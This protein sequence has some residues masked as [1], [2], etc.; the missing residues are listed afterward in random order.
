M[1]FALLCDVKESDTTI[2]HVGPDPS[3]FFFCILRIKK[4]HSISFIRVN[5]IV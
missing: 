5:E 2:D 1:I 4:Y 3:M